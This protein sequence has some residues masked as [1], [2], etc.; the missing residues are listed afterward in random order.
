MP[1][2]ARKDVQPVRQGCICGFSLQGELSCSLLLSVNVLVAKLRIAGKEFFPRTYDKSDCTSRTHQRTLGTGQ[3]PGVKA[4]VRPPL[5]E[6]S[7]TSCWPFFLVLAQ[8]VGSSGWPW[9]MVWAGIA[10]RL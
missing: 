9:E 10:I 5:V 3:E 1:L 6:K 2:E 8:P 7:I 4:M